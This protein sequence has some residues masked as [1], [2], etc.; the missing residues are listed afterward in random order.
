MR[1]QPVL[2]AEASLGA[3]L[4]VLKPAFVENN[5]IIEWVELGQA[6]LS[7]FKEKWGLY[8]FCTYG[9]FPVPSIAPMCPTARF[10]SFSPEVTD[11]QKTGSFHIFSSCISLP[12]ERS[13]WAKGL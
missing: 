6:F 11:L 4:G 10:P 3:S 13:R 5:D 7:Q 9:S 2:A 8:D 1:P 12:G